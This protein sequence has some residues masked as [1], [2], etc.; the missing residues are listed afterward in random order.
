MRFLKTRT[1]IVFSIIMLTS[2]VIGISYGTFVY[3]TEGY[4]ASEM[5]VG[6]LMYG[7]TI[8]EDGSTSTIENNKVTIPSNTKG[9]FYV[10]I[11][12][13]NPIDSKYTLGY[14]SNNNIDVQYTDKTN[15][16]PEGLIKGYDE[17]TYS[18]KVK[19]IIDNTS[20]TTSSEVIFNVFGGYTYNSYESIS[21]NDGYL[22]I[23]GPFIETVT[24]TNRLVD[25]IEKDTSCVTE[26]NSNCLYGD[27]ISNYVQYPENSDTSKN[28]WRILGTY[29]VDGKVLSKIISIVDYTTSKETLK[30]DL[31]S[32]SKTLEDKERYI[33]S[34]NK[35]NCNTNGCSET[36]YNDLGLLTRYEY[37]LIGGDNSYLNNYSDYYILNNGSVENLKD[38]T[39]TNSNLRPVV[40][41]KTE[42]KVTGSGTIEEPYRFS[43]G[44]DINLLA[45]T[46]D[47]ETTDKTYEWLKKY[48]AVNK[49][50][51]ENGTTANWIAGENAIK[52]TNVQVPDYC[53]IDF[54]DGY[55]VTLTAVN[56]TITSANSVVVGE[57]GSVTFNITPNDGYQLS[58]STIT[59]T[60]TATGTTTSTGV[61]ISNIT[62]SQTCSVTLKSLSPTLAEA[63]LRDNPTVSKRTDF[64]AGFIDN[65]TGTIF[66]QVSTSSVPK[67]EDMNG[68]GVGEDV[69]YYAGN[70]T[71]NWVKFGGFYW[72]IIR[73]NE[74]KSIRVLY[75][76]LTTDTT[77][78][79]IASGTQFSNN[80]TERLYIG[81]MYGTSGSLESSRTNENSSN[82]KQEIDKF[83]VNNLLSYD[84]YVSKDAI[85]CNDRSIG[86]GTYTSNSIYFGSWMRNYINKS[87][88]YRCGANVNNGLY[89]STQAIAD[90]FSSSTNGGGNG[91]LKCSVYGYTDK[92]CPI[93]L[94]TAD[95]VVFAGGITSNVL[96]SPYAWYLT[97][98]VGTFIT[99]TTNWWLLSPSY[100]RSANEPEITAIFSGMLAN[101]DLKYTARVMAV[102][103]VLSLAPCAKVTG[104]GTPTDPYIVD[105]TYSTC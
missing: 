56:G 21:L 25:V 38:N 55:T 96:S 93:A 64:T 102:R 33:E 26:T 48:K 3:V 68:D 99:G 67:T 105:E 51:C 101:I 88:S 76:G 60:G 36:T 43:R 2:L 30:S 11:S 79:F 41:I 94:M 104:T 65:T 22:S 84:K 18:K 50:T 24:G 5:M 23:K 46:L 17:K 31:N 32:F 69:Y 70:T 35:F 95:E 100:V 85:Y 62:S 58:G 78:G 1:G 103:P 91:K 28:L 34:T 19:I 8:E 42:T 83:Y 61:K 49:I 82:I 71:N 20:N 74:D 73:I 14:K 72:R 53:T 29:S 27:S 16:M 63:I 75:A 57:N 90:K 4:K 54:K 15:W 80:T 40:Y 6:N 39:S 13:V 12:S 59:C 98:S 66:K 45:Y 81:Y 89:E 37:D 47:G 7:I 97:N 92:D 10:I 9:Y 52:F 87:P 86:S 77:N 44:Q